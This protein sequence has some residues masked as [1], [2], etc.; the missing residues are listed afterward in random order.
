[1]TTDP[2]PVRLQLVNVGCGKLW[3]PDWINLDA[4]PAASEVRRYDVTRGLPFADSEVDAVY[5]SHVV[6]H[7]SRAD[8]ARLI[9]DMRRVLKPSGIVRIVVPDLEAVAHLYLE[10][11]QCVLDGRTEAEAD[12]DWVMLELLDQMARDASGGEMGEFLANPAIANRAF[13]E[14]RIGDEARRYWASLE[15]GRL[16]RLARRLKGRGVGVVA[17]RAWDRAIETVLRILAGRRAADAFRIGLF[18]STGETHRWM[19]DRYSMARLLAGSG[20]SAP[21]TTSAF[22]SRIPEFSKYGLDAVDGQVR[23]PDSLF[24]EAHKP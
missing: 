1:M 14:S 20:F 7:L 16:T 23:K 22:E 19:Y 18:R 9:R 21:C 8:A 5:C 17:S 13:V 4:V 24:V 15:S 6:E 11:L 2:T 3:H 12:Y 10:K